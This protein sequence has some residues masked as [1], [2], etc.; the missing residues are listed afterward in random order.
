MHKQFGPPRKMIFRGG[1]V[2]FCGF[3]PSGGERSGLLPFPQLDQ[4]VSQNGYILKLQHF[5]R[6]PTALGGGDPII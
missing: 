1:P 5:G 4:P 2:F 3:M 6:F